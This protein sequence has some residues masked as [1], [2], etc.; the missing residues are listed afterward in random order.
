MMAL[1]MAST[2]W[3]PYSYEGLAP[4]FATPKFGRQG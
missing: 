1:E 3:F 2:H 4:A